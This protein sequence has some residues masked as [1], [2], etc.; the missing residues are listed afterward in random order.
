[1]NP[2][3]YVKQKER[4]IKRKLEL[5]SLKGG[6]CELCGYNKNIGALEFHHLDPSIK[7]FNLDE[8]HLS[9]RTIDK[10]LQEVEKCILVCSNCHKEIHYPHL[11]N[12]NI[13][14]FLLEFKTNSKKITDK[15]YKTTTCKVCGKEFKYIK[16]KIYCCSECRNKDKQYP[17]KEEIFLMYDKLK[18][19]EEVSRYFNISRKVIRKI[20]NS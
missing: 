8:R 3:D 9:N 12:K 18:T 20:R 15:K 19:W 1:M 4:A 16:G 13:E 6:K 11:D 2:N 5:I 10:I 14:N 7:M 17:T